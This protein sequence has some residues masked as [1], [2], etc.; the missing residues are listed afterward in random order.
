MDKGE[1]PDAEPRA[2]LDQISTEWSLLR[3]SE[4]FVRRYTPAVRKYLHAMIKNRHDAEDVLHDFLV[5]VLAHGFLRVKREGGRFRDYLKTAVRNAALNHL[6]RKVPPKPA[7]KQLG[8]P[9]AADPAPPAADQ[10]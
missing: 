6:L 5:R 2:R 3:D 4:Q 9:P 10:E 1:T 8:R 7:G